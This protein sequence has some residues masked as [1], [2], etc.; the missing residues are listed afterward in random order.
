MKKKSSS[1][2]RTLKTVKPSDLGDKLLRDQLLYLLKGGGAHVSFDDAMG[3]WPEQLGGAK[4]ANFPHTAWMLLEHMRL[5]QWD[6]LEFSRNSKH[7]SPAWPEGYW[8][9]SEA[10]ANEKA[11]KASIAAFKK[12]LRT[13]ERLVADR[14]VDL[15]ARIPWGDGQTILR[16]ALLVADHNAYHLGQLVMLRKSIGI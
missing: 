10:P 9:A 12:D 2:K 16:E 14:R 4:V 6:I 7:V 15:H 13:M 11:W 1:K 3:D 5:A 8:P